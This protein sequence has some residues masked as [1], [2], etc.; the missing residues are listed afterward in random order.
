MLGFSWLLYYH[1]G[2]NERGAGFLYWQ[3]NNVVHS[4]VHLLNKWGG[5]D[6]IPIQ[7]GGRSG[8]DCMPFLSDD[9]WDPFVHSVLRCRFQKSFRSTY[10][11]F[12]F[13]QVSLVKDIDSC[14]ADRMPLECL[15]CARAFHSQ[16]ENLNLSNLCFGDYGRKCFCYMLTLHVNSANV[17]YIFIN[18]IVGTYF[19]AGKWVRFVS[20]T[21][22][23][24]ARPSTFEPI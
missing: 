22:A 21:S 19:F 15:F 20:W 3:L 1:V 8:D 18:N 24:G 9:V 12:Q 2:A 14:Q 4:A 11:P 5:A 23:S 7:G 10:C 13:T 16:T 17:C 6:S